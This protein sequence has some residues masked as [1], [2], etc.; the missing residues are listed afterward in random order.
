M[1]CHSMQREVLVKRTGCVPPAFLRG[2]RI[3]DAT[4]ATPDASSVAIDVL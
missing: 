1:I 2:E 4:L 3:A